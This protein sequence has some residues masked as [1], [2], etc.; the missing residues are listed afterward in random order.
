MRVM[1][2]NKERLGNMGIVYCIYIYV[3]IYN[4]CVYIYILLKFFYT[5][6][7][8]RMNKPKSV[9]KIQSKEDRGQRYSIEEPGH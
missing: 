5:N 4:L 8:M 1:S 2:L 7:M 6:K 9:Y 3:Y